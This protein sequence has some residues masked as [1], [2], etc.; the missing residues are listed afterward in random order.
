MSD[1][2]SYSVRLADLPALQSRIIELAEPH[3]DDRAERLL[4]QLA[5]LSDH[6]DEQPGDHEVQ[7]T[8]IPLCEDLAARAIDDLGAPAFGRRFRRGTRKR[9][10]A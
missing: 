7:F 1:E 10:P 2:I 8:P 3:E 9:A 6:A 4:G 5:A